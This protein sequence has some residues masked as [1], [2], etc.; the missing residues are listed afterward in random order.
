MNHPVVFS[1]PTPFDLPSLS[2]YEK[3]EAR[4]RAVL[5]KEGK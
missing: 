5:R 2:D 1:T 4:A 3:A